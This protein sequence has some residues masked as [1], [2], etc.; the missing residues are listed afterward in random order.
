MCIVDGDPTVDWMSKTPPSPLADVETPSLTC[1]DECVAVVSKLC[2]QH[3][4]GH[5][6]PLSSLS[7]VGSTVAS[8]H[9]VV[10]VCD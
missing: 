4:A 1:H 9:S 6:S 2:G 5:L 8:C 10:N 7:P 3:C